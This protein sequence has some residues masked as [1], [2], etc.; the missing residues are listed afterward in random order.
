[1][2]VPACE[3][4]TW[5]N[6]PFLAV[7]FFAIATLTLGAQ[8]AN[9][10]SPYSG[11]SNPPPDETIITSTTPEAKPPAGHP[12]ETQ[13]AAP[14]AAT[15]VRPAYSPHV[16]PAPL[17]T[18]NMTAVSG[19][20]TDD[21]IVQVG[22]S[23]TN[24]PQP[25]LAERSYA[26]DPD[27]DIVHPALLGPGD[28]GEGTVIRVQL[29]DDLSSSLSEPGEPFHSRV[30][31]DVMQ[32]GH[33]V[34]PAGAEIDGRV[35]DVSTGHFGGHGSML[36][37]PETVVMPDGAKIKLYAMVEGTPGTNSHVGSEGVITPNRRLKTGGLEYGGAVGVGVIAGASLGGPAG[38]LA[39]GL[40]G[41]GLVTTHLLVNHAQTNLD[42]GSYV[43]LILTETMHMGQSGAVQN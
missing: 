39:G 42:Q 22:Q 29:L 14:A 17:R 2:D 41:A 28:L 30:A 12:I 13:T 1:M 34:I 19:D 26:A 25:A 10:S 27:G 38:A 21:G 40:I 20:G 8:E 3:K 35:A 36:L 9:Q 7:A 32:G 37:H 11:V 18:A 5:M 24:V 43:D 33:V 16:T 23:S 15:P 31:L 6:R 4:E